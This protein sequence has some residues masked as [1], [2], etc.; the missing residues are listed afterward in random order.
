LDDLGHGGTADRVW[1]PVC[2]PPSR[3]ALLT[4]A[5]LPVVEDGQLFTAGLTVL[6]RDLRAGAAALLGR[7]WARRV[8]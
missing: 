5:G 6:N 1:A 3:L 2:G 4:L 7:D 8:R